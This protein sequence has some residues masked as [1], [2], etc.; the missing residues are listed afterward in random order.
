MKIFVCK[1]EEC[2][3]SCAFIDENPP[4]ECPMGYGEIGG[5]IVQTIWR[6]RPAEWVE[7]G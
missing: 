1:S 5:F 2:G 4:A 6:H 7:E 3:S